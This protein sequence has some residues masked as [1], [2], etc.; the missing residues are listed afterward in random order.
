M[1][2]RVGSM[3]AGIGGTCLGF[4]QAGA[5][6]VWANEI[7]ANACITYRNY[8]GDTYLQE[9]DITQID[10]ST[11]PELDILI[12]GFPCQAFSI[13]GYR[14]GFEDDR[15]NVF[16]Q[17]L[18]VLEA[19]RNVYGRLPQAIMLE[20]VKNLFTHD[21]GN[22][23]R[24]IKEALEAYGY[25]VKA[26]VLN[27][28]EYGNVPQNRER[29]YIVG[30]Q[31][32]NQAEMFRFPEPIPLTNQLNDVVDRTRRYDERYYYDETSQ[33]YEMLR[34]AMVSTDTTYQLRRIYVRENRSNVCPTLTANMGTGGHNVPL[35]LDYENNIRKL[36]PEECLLLQGFPADYHYPE[37]MAN[38][39]KYKQAG[40]SVTVPVIRRI[41]TNIINVLNGETNAND[42]QE[43]QYAITQ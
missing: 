11:I 34:E 9:G 16:F 39:H 1:T 28:M 24:V 22:T 17:I 25:T 14:K 18:E 23:F 29:I 38:S 40:N 5:E 15:G 36:T 33:Y 19:Q 32:E 37:G 35:V 3:F 13:A 12:G 4:I 43:H 2:Y 41:A 10:K 26:E 8:F 31:D 27:S 6:I 30:F 42:E 20:N 21:K 7:D